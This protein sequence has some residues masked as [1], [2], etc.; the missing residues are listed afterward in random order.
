MFEDTT[1]LPTVFDPFELERAAAACCGR[2]G[3][4]M[5][6]AQRLVTLRD[7][8]AGSTALAHQLEAF[9]KAAAEHLRGVHCTANMQPEAASLARAVVAWADRLHVAA[10]AHRDWQEEQSLMDTSPI[11]RARASLSSL[12]SLP[13][14]PASSSLS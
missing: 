5:A 11:G 4:P 2:F 10:I 6:E 13:P 9:A 12:P 14:L 7:L 3:D 1:P 8:I